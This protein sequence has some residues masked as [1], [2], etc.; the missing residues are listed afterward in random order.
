MLLSDWLISI[1]WQLNFILSVGIATLPTSHHT[2][3]GR[4]LIE[5][6]LLGEKSQYRCP[7]FEDN[8]ETGVIK[9]SWSNIL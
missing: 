6:E 5:N 7:I 8:V 3:A 4:Q 1:A 2:T 9:H